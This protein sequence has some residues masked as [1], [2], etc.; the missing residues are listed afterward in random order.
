MTAAF[1]GHTGRNMLEI[2]SVVCWALIGMLTLLFGSRLGQ[3]QIGGSD[4]VQHRRSRGALMTPQVGS[5]L[6][7]RLRPIG[8]IGP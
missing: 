6:E 2:E 7:K 4:R 1:V 3:V 5:Y 8:R